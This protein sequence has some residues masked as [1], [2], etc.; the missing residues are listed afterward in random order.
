[1]EIVDR[2]D[3]TLYK[4]PFIGNNL[5]DFNNN[6][7]DFE[8][9]QTRFHNNLMQL[10]SGISGSTRI[11]ETTNVRAFKVNGDY[12]EM[13][14]PDTSDD[15]RLYSIIEILTF[16]GTVERYYYFNINYFVIYF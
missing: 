8:I 3:I 2:S 10:F 7:A 14:L 15:V 1:M 11:Y 5:L 13:V 12:M 6:A 16:D 4:F 9:F